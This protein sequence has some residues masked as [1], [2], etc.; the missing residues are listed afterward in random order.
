MDKP[1]IT[2][3][4]FFFPLSHVHILRKGSKVLNSGLSS[5]KFLSASNLFIIP[6]NIKNFDLS[7]PNETTAIFDPRLFSRRGIGPGLLLRIFAGL[8]TLFDLC[9][10]VEYV[11]YASAKKTQEK[12]VVRKHH[13]Y[14]LT[15]NS[16][17]KVVLK[18]EQHEE[19]RCDSQAI[20]GQ[21]DTA[22]ASPGGGR[23]P[24]VTQ[25]GLV[26]ITNIA[27]LAERLREGRTYYVSVGA[28]AR[29]TLLNPERFE[30]TE[31]N[32]TVYK[33]Y[34]S[35]DFRR[36][37]F[38]GEYLK[39][40]ET[41]PLANQ[42]RYL[43]YSPET[44]LPQF[45]YQR[46]KFDGISHQPISA[47]VTLVGPI[48]S[49][50]AHINPPLTRRDPHS[51]GLALYALGYTR[52]LSEK[53]RNGLLPFYVS[54]SFPVNFQRVQELQP[55]DANF[56]LPSGEITTFPGYGVAW[57]A[58]DYRRPVNITV[59]IENPETGKSDYVKVA[60]LDQLTAVLPKMLEA[61]ERRQRA[62]KA[63]R[64]VVES[65]GIEYLRGMLATGDAPKLV[66]EAGA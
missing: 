35:L 11:V 59:E 30:S 63:S 40:M 15:F 47:T 12:K 22:S 34:M 29:F 58:T 28:M 32:G 14:S 7:Q 57:C 62:D 8:G 42:N 49:D 46:E 66:G 1:H 65:V 27:Q 18:P 6:S 41:H 17:T 20:R 2:S 50:G 31:V 23:K 39:P 33:P 36:I 43:R 48:G 60:T 13:H 24:L 4:D 9:F 61:A 38:H 51:F 21:A 53:H 37:T 25:T 19:W 3:E 55:E 52:M 10:V 54:L 5:Q 45:T 26:I 56:K 16:H 64:E 44:G